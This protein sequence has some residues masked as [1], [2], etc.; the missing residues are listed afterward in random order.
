MENTVQPIALRPLSPLT[1]AAALLDKTRLI[2]VAAFLGLLATRG[3]VDPDYFWHLKTGEFIVT[4]MA[5]PDGDIFSH[6]RF[7]QEWVLHEW[8]FEVILY[9]AYAIGGDFAV[10]LMT[11][12]LGLLAI[13]IAGHCALRITG[14]RAAACIA[15]AVGFLPFA[16]SITPRP[17]LISFCLAAY[18]LSTLLDFKYRKGSVSMLWVPAAMVVWVNAHGGFV[19]GV[20]F[21]F[22]F[23]GC[24]W[25]RAWFSGAYAGAADKARLLGLTKVCALTLLA[26]L[27]NPDFIWHWAYPVMVLGMKANAVI[28]EWQSPNFHI[29]GPEQAYLGA[30]VVFVLAYIYAARKRDITELAIPGLFILNGFISMRHMALASLVAVPF[31][32]L[33]LHDG[34]LAKAA[35]WWRT[36]AMARALD[37]VPGARH[38]LGTR[39]FVL[40]W[41]LLL[42]LVGGFA[43]LRPAFEDKKKLAL[44]HVYPVKAADFVVANGIGG[45]MYNEY[46]HGGY[47]IYRLAPQIKVM[48]DGRADVYGDE[49][50]MDYGVMSTGRQGWKEK[51]AAMNVDF[52]IT[53]VDSPIRQL[54]LYTGE[55]REVYADSK[56]AVLLRNRPAPSPGSQVLRGKS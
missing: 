25:L 3:L 29:A 14:D 39:E 21:L 18:Y 52:A 4:N 34:I 20:A 35:G 1:Q 54:M 49:L 16:G 6:V 47:L 33:A 32:A 27:V 30:V 22:A 2:I 26:T 36:S 38:E 46:N 15:V 28:V 12:S 8:L 37:R 44:E 45:R 48:I 7:G 56:F 23:T 41:I 51:L 55:F 31:L 50:I 9:G 40:N 19:V 11:A 42:I 13:L 10:T 53:N 43:A 24:E 5:L 17:Q